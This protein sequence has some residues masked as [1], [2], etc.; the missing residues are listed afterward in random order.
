VI[1]ASG[2]ASFSGTLTAQQIS[3]NIASASALISNSL[4]TENA[5]ILGTLSTNTLNATEASISGKIIAK[6]VEAENIN[7]IQRLLA[8]IRN[9]PLPDLNNQTNLANTTDLNCREQSCLFSTI[10]VT[11][12][13]NLYNV[14]VSGSLLVGQTFVENNSITTLASEMR[15]S[16]LDKITLF[17]G[18]VTIAKNGAITT[19]GEI[20][21]QG[22]IKTSKI[23]PLEKEVSVLGNLSILGDLKLK[24]ATDSAVIAAPDNLAKNGIFAP[25]MEASASVAGIGII[26]KNSQEV[27]IYSSFAKPNSLIYLTPKNSQP[28]SLSVFDKKDGFF[29]VI[30]NE[31]LDQDITFDWLIIN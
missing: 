24:K 5:S 19:K 6:E 18:A 22:G 23:T 16:A 17:D 28:I 30:R 21:A 15:L 9:Q 25:A 26:P 13:S 11:G 12:Q 14:S 2:N 27:V 8:E 20:I 29:Q 7:E 31:L 1:D 10:T 3:T 4:K